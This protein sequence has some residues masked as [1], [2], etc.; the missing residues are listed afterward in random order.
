MFLITL[1]FNEI[2]PVQL[3][4]FIHFSLLLRNTMKKIVLLLIFF[5]FV[6]S[7]KPENLVSFNVFHGNKTFS[8]FFNESLVDRGCETAGNFSFV[9]HGWYGSGYDSEWIPD[10]IANLQE[11][12]GG[13]IIFMNYSFYSDRL[14][15]L[16]SI[17]F[18]KPVSSVLL[19]KLWQMENEGISGDSI[20]MFGFSFGGRIVIEAAVN[21]GKQKIDKI[22]SELRN[23]KKNPYFVVYI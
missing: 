17:S 5:V 10:L 12:R 15:Y 19:K 13:C 2:V 6:T 20:F 8:S 21:F 14:N 22:D 9:V 16:E 4:V 7:Q 3:S 1:D 18:F 23:I 11:F